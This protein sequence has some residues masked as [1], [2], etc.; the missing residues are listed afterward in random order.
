[1]TAPTV[2]SEVDGA[3]FAYPTCWADMDRW[4]TEVAEIRRTNPILRVDLAGF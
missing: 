4:H 3:Q 2:T 1:M